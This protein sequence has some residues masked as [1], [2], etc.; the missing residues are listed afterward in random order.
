MAVILLI[1]NR[2]SHFFTVRFF[3]KFA[4]KYLLKT[5]PHLICVTALPCE[6]LASENKRQSQ[7][8]AVMNDILQGTVVTYLRCGGI[9]NNQIKINLLLSLQVKFVKSVNISHS[10]GQK[11]N[12]VDQ[13]LRLLSVWWP[14]AQS[15]RDNLVLA[16]NFAKYSPILNFSLA[17]SAINLS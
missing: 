7:T 13:F 9:V 16:C 10:C 8:N 12:C 6:T 2:F 17:D 1:L 3:N 15:A 14:C 4:G 11:M 5:P